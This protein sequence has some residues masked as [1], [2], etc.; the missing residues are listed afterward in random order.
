MRPTLIAL[1]LA[2]SLLAATAGLFFSLGSAPASKEG[3]GWDPSGLDSP[4]PPPQVEVGCG[5]DPNGQNS[6]TPPEQP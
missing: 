6:C 3:C 4:A 5:W 1:I 2:A